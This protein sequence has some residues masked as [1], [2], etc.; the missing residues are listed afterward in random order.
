[1]RLDDWWNDQQQQFREKTEGL[2]PALEFELQGRMDEAQ[3]PPDYDAPGGMDQWKQAEQSLMER[4]LAVD[5]KAEEERRRQEEEQLQE[6]LRLEQAQAQQKQQ[7]EE[8]QREMSMLDQARSL[9]IPTPEDAFKDFQEPGD[10]TS[11]TGIFDQGS[12]PVD[13]FNAHAGSMMSDVFGSP[14][15]PDQ[16]QP[17]PRDDTSSSGILD[18]RSYW[19]PTARESEGMGPAVGPEFLPEGIRRAA[20]VATRAVTGAA[21]AEPAGPEWLPGGVRQ[22]VGSFGAAMEPLQAVDDYRSA[23]LDPQTWAF[24]HDGIARTELDPGELERWN[25]LQGSLS[26]EGGRKYAYV[27]PEEQAEIDRITGKVDRIYQS[28]KDDPDKLNDYAKASPAYEA[29]R[30]ITGTVLGGALGNVVGGAAGSAARGLGAGHRAIKAAEYAGDIAAQTAFDPTTPAIQPLGDLAIKGLGAG[31]RGTR[32][33]LGRA[34]EALVRSADDVPADVQRLGSGAVPELGESIPPHKGGSTWYHGSRSDFPYFD[35]DKFDPDGDWGPGAY[36]TSDADTAGIFA[37]DNMVDAAEGGNVRKIGLPKKINLINGDKP[38]DATEAGEAALKNINTVFQEAFGKSPL[39]ESW[40]SFPYPFDMQYAALVRAA[41]GDKTFV[42][43]ILSDAGYDGVRWRYEGAEGR[44]KPAVVVFEPSLAK[45]RNEFSGTAGGSGVIPNL[46]RPLFNA[47]QGG[48]IGAVSEPLEYDEEGR[49]INSASRLRN[50]GIG[51][52]LAMLAGSRGARRVAGRAL[53]AVGSGVVPEG[54][55]G[56]VDVEGMI[57]AIRQMRIAGATDDVILG[58]ERH[59]A[60]NTDLTLPDVQ[61]RTREMVSATPSEPLPRETAPPSVEEPS[62]SPYSGGTRASLPTESTPY[63]RGLTTEE[64]EQMGLPGFENVPRT[65]TPQPRQGIRGFGTVPQDMSEDT[66]RGI[67]GVAGEAARERAPYTLQQQAEDVGALLDA[68]PEA[69]KPILGRALLASPQASAIEQGMLREN[70]RTWGDA[71]AKARQNWVDIQEEIA[72]LTRN[73]RVIPDDVAEE[74]TLRAT[75][76]AEVYNGLKTAVKGQS[77]SAAAHSRGLN[78]QKGARLGA[79][80]V[81]ESRRLDD[82]GDVAKKAAKSIKDGVVDE[83]ALKDVGTKLGSSRTRKAVTG[84]S[85][86]GESL[87]P[88]TG[89][90]GGGK[91]SGTPRTRSGAPSE[92]REETLIEKLG[93]LM[94]EQGTLENRLEESSQATGRGARTSL[95]N[96]LHVTDPAER[97]VHAGRLAEVRA[98]IEDIHGQMR[99]HAD[100]LAQQRLAAKANRGP[101][102]LEETERIVNEAIGRKA[103]ARMTREATRKARGLTGDEA[104]ITKGIKEG[105]DRHYKTAQSDIQKEFEKLFTDEA[106]REAKM[107]LW[108]D[109][110]VDGILAQERNAK[111]RKEVKSLSDV[112]QSW[113][114]DIRDDANPK[115]NP[116]RRAQLDDL[117]KDVDLRQELDDVLVEMRSH[118]TVGER[119]ANDL[120]GRLGVNLDKDDILRTLRDQRAA[121]REITEA[122][123]RAVRQQIQDVLDNPRAPDRHTRIAD[124]YQDL[125]DI[126]NEGKKRASEMRHRAHDEG[127]LKSGLDASGKSSDELAKM[128]AAVD[129]KDPAS[130]KPILELMARPNAWGVLREISFINMLSNAKTHTTNISSTAYNGALRLLLRNPVEQFFSR[131]ELSGSRAAFE[132]LTAGAKE[133]LRLAGKTMTT[134]INPRRIESAVATGE[135]QHIGR[136]LLPEVL[137]KVKLGKLGQAMHFVSTRPLEA[138]DA[139]MGNMMYSSATHQ[140]AQR[141]ADDLIRAGEKMIDGVPIQNR[142]QAADH[143]LK[144]IWDHPEII[145]DAG[146]IEDYTLFR[147]RDPGKFER[148]L[149]QAMGLKELGPNPTTRDVLQA[150]LIDMVMPFFNVPYNFTKQG[151]G[152]VAHGLAAVPREFTTMG[153]GAKMLRGQNKEAGELAARSA[154]GAAMMAVPMYFAMSGD[155]WDDNITAQGPTDAGQRRVWMENHRPYSFRWPGTASWI[156]YEGTPVAIPFAAV[157]GGAEAIQQ[158]QDSP[159]KGSAGAQALGIGLGALKGAGQGALSQTFLEGAQRNIEALTGDIKG[160]NAGAQVLA[161]LATRY[162]PSPVPTGMLSFLAQMTDSVERDPGRARSLDDVLPV[163]ADVVKSRIPGLRNQ[164]P[165]RRGAF[166]EVVDN[167]Y[168]GGWAAVPKSLVGARAPGEGDPIVS[169]LERGGVGIPN[170]PTD[171]P[172]GE[173]SV[174]LTIKEQQ[175]YQR[176]WGQEYYK[177]LKEMGA[178][179]ET[180]TDVELTNMRNGA[181]R[182]AAGAVLDTLTNPEIDRRWVR[183][184]VLEVAP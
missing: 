61:A 34:G 43:G 47:A 20:G 88:G 58:A 63:T 79:A 90:G 159:D 156:S 8:H 145:K 5:Q 19:T 136:E 114:K 49:P 3:I 118:S 41:D 82:I 60:E 143:I 18:Q 99:T 72:D 142:E 85:R 173:G 161:G 36:L 66:E 83:D 23:R 129:P 167:P 165:E 144:N 138:M 93:R 22:A 44:F 32:G 135:Y 160:P 14:P 174:P 117:K 86:I 102:T 64:A 6:Q 107:K 13:Q 108:H 77:L 179:K 170:A 125:E 24:A 54:G 168:S 147:S 155:R 38:L 68:D 105:I 158:Q 15:D 56:K 166:G 182:M 65:E 27:T 33:V 1:V 148:L 25:D 184:P 101:L 7:D 10:H 162:A 57:Q 55:A 124:L 39:K 2:M 134:G 70:S 98:E 176:V 16:T 169:Q 35:P 74:A 175:M 152:N 76:L 178:G 11:T 92:P 131:G 180:F 163:A 133:G 26:A 112:A 126:G 115:L 12:S 81:A 172:M 50:I 110:R 51:A 171:L 116:E 183:K 21:R 52:G 91:G 150:A 31:V 141:K 75:T 17:P 137:G 100:E 111:T 181:R 113:A 122:R 132:G 89:E 104:G 164:L 30:M 149:R 53:Q 157:A 94:R 28:I 120:E 69:I 78:A 121:G 127:I 9:G 106:K 95:P 177:L 97:G 151:L 71:W 109:R 123:I 103:Q 139:L 59:L 130:V 96:P 67:R 40:R 62:P 42:N 46:R 84:T 73:G 87:G 140:L 128:M 48:V 153:V 154:Q 119:V 146:K 37:A 29:T 4:G 80:A 45:M